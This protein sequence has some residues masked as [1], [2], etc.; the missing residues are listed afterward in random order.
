MLESHHRASTFS[1]LPQSDDETYRLA[2]Q[3]KANRDTSFAAVAV[4]ED[5]VV[6]FV[7]ISVAEY[8]LSSEGLI[9]TI[10]LLIVN[11]LALTPFARTKTMLRLLALSCESAK[12]SVFV[13]G[14]RYESLAGTRG[15]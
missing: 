15:I 14:Y 2:G 9:A 13:Q 7:W 5:R 4:D 1:D 6:G 10:R 12:S 11:R 3:V 8:V